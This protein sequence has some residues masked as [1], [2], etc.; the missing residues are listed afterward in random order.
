LKTTEEPSRFDQL[1][2]MGIR[3]L[4]EGINREDQGVAQ[5]VHQKIDRIEALVQE[6]VPRMEKG[7]RVFYIGAGTSGRLGIVDASEIPPT[8]GTPNNWFIG[9]IAGGDGAIRKAVEFAEDD[10]D[11]AWQDL[12]AFEIG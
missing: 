2:H 4:L 10:E 5:S 3:D 6:I 11:Q 7:G 1:E 12:L 9:L 8:F